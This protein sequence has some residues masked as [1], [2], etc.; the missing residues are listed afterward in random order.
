MVKFTF[1]ACVWTAF[2][3]ACRLMV[4]VRRW[5]GDRQN[6]VITVAKE[7]CVMMMDMSDFTRLAM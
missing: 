5:G 6:D 7:M 3:N 4:E 1:A 2:V